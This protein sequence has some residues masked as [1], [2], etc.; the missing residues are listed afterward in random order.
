MYK[1]LDS[2]TKTVQFL[3]IQIWLKNT[4][5]DG[6]VAGIHFLYKIN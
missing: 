4:Y 3:L 1:F 6:Y 5:K 2:E